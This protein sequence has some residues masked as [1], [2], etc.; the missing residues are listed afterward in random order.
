MPITRSKKLV[1]DQM[2]D[3]L[4][5][6]FVE[7]TELTAEGL[8]YQR[9]D[10]GVL[11]EI[12]PDAFSVKPTISRSEAV[13]LFGRAI[14]ECR[15]ADTVTAHAIAQRAEAI[16][17]AT[18]AVPQVPFTLWTKFRARNMAQ[19]SGFNLH[20]R[21]VRLRSAAH[22]PSWLQRDDYLL[23]GVGHIYPHK[24]ESFGHVILSCK[25]RDEERAVDR[26]L[27]ALQL[28]LGLL[29]MYETWQRHSSWG[30]RNWTEGGL[31]QGPTQFVFRNRQFRGEDRI[32][33]NPD[34]DEEAWNRHPPHMQR[35][36][37][38]VPVARRALAALETHPLRNVLV[39]AILLLQDGFASRDGSHRLLRYWSALEQLYVEADA[40]G[41]SN[42]KVVERAVFAE[43]EPHLSRWKLEHIARLRNQYVHAGGSGDDLHNMGQFLREMVARHINHWIFHGH[44]FANHAALLDYVKLP[45]NRDALV[46]M[47]DLID[48]RMAL[49]DSI[50]NPE[51]NAD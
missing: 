16:Q 22:L 27:E 7:G 10:F 34:Y 26:M 3:A 39:R 50:S 15:R 1:S 5:R 30:G 11:Y 2:L 48:R 4:V 17:K 36:L 49:V 35:I 14:R 6:Q 42:E 47:R 46:Q 33:Y 8:S 28:M 51:G 41:R 25:D 13:R 20:W 23:S 44:T 40:K 37:R 21:D 29:N 12:L 19:N 24:P 9:P 18:L 32:W 43:R 38:I 31:W 45:P